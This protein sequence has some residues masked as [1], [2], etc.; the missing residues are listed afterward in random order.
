MTMWNQVVEILRESMFAYAHASN[1]NMATGI[2]AVTFLARLALFPLMFR[3]SL[4]AARHH[5]RVRMIQPELDAVKVRFKDDPRR[6]MEETRRIFAR[7]GISMLP[8]GSLVGGLAQA[9]VLLALY[10]AVRQCAAVG[11]RFL[12]IADLSRPDRVVAVIVTALA[13]AGIWLAPPPPGQSRTL[14][15]LLPALVT[16]IVLWKMAAGIGLYWG[17]STAFGTV[18]TLITRRDRI[19]PRT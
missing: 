11:G 10:S 3:L 13:G 1:G 4:T 19:E 17:V 14:V 15:S 8:L 6:L 2:L 18:Q 16:M 9:P 7:E 12:W 5:E